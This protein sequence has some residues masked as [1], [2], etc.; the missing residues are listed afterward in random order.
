MLMESLCGPG[1]ITML[2]TPGDASRYPV[3]M[4]YAPI[5]TLARPI[6]ASCVLTVL[7][8][9][10]M[11]THPCHCYALCVPLDCVYCDAGDEGAA[12]LVEFTDV[13][14]AEHCCTNLQGRDRAPGIHRQYPPFTFTD[15][16]ARRLHAHLRVRPPSMCYRPT[17][18]CGFHMT[19][20]LPV[21]SLP[22][23]RL[24]VSAAGA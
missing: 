4:L 8:L 2:H 19:L 1:E 20:P 9:S 15:I 7:I 12:C 3:I 18:S 6:L 11:Y 21:F 22:R 24:V 14:D 23:Q 17:P 16:I 5:P 13:T 10:P